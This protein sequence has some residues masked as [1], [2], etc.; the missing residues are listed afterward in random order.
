MLLM[1]VTFAVA[2][3]RLAHRRH[4]GPADERD[5]EPRLGRHDLRRQDRHPDRRRAAAARASRSPRGSRRSRRTP[6][7]RASR[8]A[9]ATATGPWRRSPSASPATPARVGGEV[10]FSSEWKWSGLRIGAHAATC[11]AP[12]TSST[13]AGALT[14]PPEPRA[15]CSS[16]ETAAGRRVVAFGESRR[17]AARR[18]RRGEAPPRLAP[19]ALVVL[20]ET[21]R[22]DAAETIAF[23]REQEVDLKLIS[24]DA[25]ATVTAVAG[26]VGVPADAGVDRGP[27]PAR[28]TRRSWPRSRS[29]NTI[30]C[31]IAPEQKKALVGAL[32]G[33]GPLHGD[34]RRRRQRRAG[35]EAGAAGGGDGLR[36]PG[37]Q[38]A[39]PTSSC[40]RTS[41]R[42]CRK[43]SPKAGG[44]PATSTASAAST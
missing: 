20:E 6:R 42:A 27:R 16:E 30:F 28:A 8:P 31:R 19:L 15:R 23:M 44:S 10:P 40:S 33:V 38:R 22:P 41:S 5:R 25:R 3:V 11:W 18:R 9:P 2:A 13:R 34:D 17:A 43:R 26:A 7:W 39:S 21:L 24:G 35:A 4:A 1:S 37:D 14:L 12:R 32:R 29:A 36:R